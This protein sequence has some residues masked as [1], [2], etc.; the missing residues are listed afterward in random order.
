MSKERVDDTSTLSNSVK[1][2][3][4]SKD[5][6]ADKI[7]D[8]FNAVFDSDSKPEV[9]G[10]GITE[11]TEKQDAEEQVESEKD[12]QTE[13]TEKELEQESEIVDKSKESADKGVK[14]KSS[15]I[16]AAYR[17]SLKAAEWTD[18]EI[19]TASKE[20][21]SKFLTYAEK[22]HSQRNA[23]NAKMAEMGRASRPKPTDAEPKAQ[24]AKPTATGLKPF[25]KAAMRAKYG[26]DGLIDEMVDPIN[27]VISRLN[28]IM[29]SI[30]ETQNRSQIQQTETLGK[31]V[32]A[33][34]GSD[35]MKDYHDIYG[36]SS[37]NA[38]DEQLKARQIVLDHADALVAGYAKNGVRISFDDAMNGGHDALSSKYKE[39]VARESIRKN[40]KDREKGISL[41]PS[42]K[43]AG[44]SKALKGTPKEVLEQNTKKRLAAVFG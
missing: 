35:D 3:S 15:P 1:L 17:R 38:T 2:D 36:K 39:T 44:A 14:P 28:T 21:G 12:I 8:K 6:L 34:F 40:L 43:I 33:Y 32:D 27:E 20:L 7:S 16:P 25:D 29:P 5:S 13:S 18:E 4:A 19:D 42:S 23:F 10:D 31:Q 41:K 22:I 11:S 9:E 26:E 30:Q 24:E 37:I